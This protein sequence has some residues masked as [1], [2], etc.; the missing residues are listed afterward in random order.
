MFS[1]DYP[2]CQND[3]GT[4]FLASAEIGPTDKELIAHRN[5]E[6]LLGLKPS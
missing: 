6:T 1:V 4:A 3:A 2:Y 5:A